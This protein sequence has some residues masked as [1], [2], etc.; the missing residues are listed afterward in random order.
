MELQPGRSG[1]PASGGLWTAPENIPGAAEGGT[2]GSGQFGF[3][4]ERAARRHGRWQD[5][6]LY[7]LE[8]DVLSQA[9]RRAVPSGR[10]HSIG[11]GGTQGG[12][13]TCICL[14]EGTI[15]G[16]YR[17]AAPLRNA[18]GGPQRS[19]HRRGGLGR[20]SH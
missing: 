2:G 12:T 14:G 16:E 15:G 9:A 3:V 8:G 11:G 5:Q 17:G 18:S 1:Q 10:I 7:H 13:R 6:A 4:R 19:S 20:H